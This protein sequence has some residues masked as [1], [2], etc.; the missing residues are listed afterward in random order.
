MSPYARLLLFLFFT[1]MYILDAIQIILVHRHYMLEKAGICVELTVGEED[2][3]CITPR[4]GA[5]YFGLFLI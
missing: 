2:S 1:T 5:K 4:L 3:G